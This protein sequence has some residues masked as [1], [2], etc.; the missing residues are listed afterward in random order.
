MPA[1]NSNSSDEITIIEDREAQAFIHSSDRLDL[2]CEE[3]G[4]DRSGKGDRL[5]RWI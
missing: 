5:E 3:G 2:A 1:P 4:F